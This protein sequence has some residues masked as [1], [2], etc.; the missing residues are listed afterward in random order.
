[1]K[2]TIAALKAE[3]GSEALHAH[4]KAKDPV[5]AKR[6]EPNDTQRITRA[7]EVLEA[8]GKSLDKWQKETAKPPFEQA[9]FAGIFFTNERAVVYERCN[10]RLKDMVKRGALDE[11]RALREQGLDKDL[12][13]M[14]A[15]GVPHLMA[16][17]NGETNLDDAIALAQQH[18]RNYVKRQ[19]TFFTHQLPTLKAFTKRGEAL[20]YLVGAVK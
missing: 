9:Q 18:T 2:E 11:I 15:L 16:F 20:N 10:Q 14:K 8:T 7:L 5:M 6:L 1:V 4:L 12:P 19:N 3:Q 17:I 13:A